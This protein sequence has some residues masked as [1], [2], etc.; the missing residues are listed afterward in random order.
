MS[1]FVRDVDTDSDVATNAPD[2]TAANTE[3]ANAQI[4]IAI[5]DPAVPSAMSVNELLEY[6]FSQVSA[7]LAAGTNVTITPGTNPNSLTIA[8]TDTDTNTQRSEEEIYDWVAGFFS[9]TNS[10]TVTKNDTENRITLSASLPVLVIDRLSSPIGHTADGNGPGGNDYHELTGLSLSS[11]TYRFYI[12]LVRV[13]EDA[14][15]LEGGATG[16]ASQSA[17]VPSNLFNSSAERIR[18][19]TLD[20]SFCILKYQSNSTVRVFVRETGGAS[21]NECKFVALYGV[22]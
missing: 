15:D 1:L 22:R 9:N 19:D 11:S 14:G 2:I 13:W 18:I 20:N 4:P 16:W 12:M 6:I 5:G 7:W 17:I 8:S 10:V 21:A 3:L